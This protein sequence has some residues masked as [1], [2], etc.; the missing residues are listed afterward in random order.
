M[1]VIGYAAYLCLL[2]LPYSLYAVWEEL[3]T[4]R[5]VL[6]TLA[7]ALAIFIVGAYAVTLE[8]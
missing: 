1:N 6:I 5:K 4:A 3:N 8:V 2:L 7:A